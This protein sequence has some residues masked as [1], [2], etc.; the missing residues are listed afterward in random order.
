[1]VL[2]HP[3]RKI[4]VKRRVI[5]HQRKWELEIKAL[6]LQYLND[7]ACQ[8]VRS[9]LHQKTNVSV[10]LLRSVRRPGGTHAESPL[11]M[12]SRLRP[13]IP[14]AAPAVSAST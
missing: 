8:N 14:I 13:D 11:A 7:N 5:E 2:A 4:E 6:A 9:T 12:I 10:L 3:R 1:M